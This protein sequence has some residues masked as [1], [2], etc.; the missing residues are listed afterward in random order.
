VCPSQL[1]CVLK[2]KIL[3]PDSQKIKPPTH[4]APLDFLVGSVP[5]FGEPFCSLVVVNSGCL[6]MLLWASDDLFF[7]CL[8]LSCSEHFVV[9]KAR[10]ISS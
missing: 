9:I 3:F 10:F 8:F 6:F 1:F 7:L 5:S 4:L 2:R